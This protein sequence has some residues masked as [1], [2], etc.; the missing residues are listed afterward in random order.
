MGRWMDGLDGC[1]NWAIKY[2]LRYVVARIKDESEA[3]IIFAR[4]DT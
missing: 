4:L 2:V 1:E 3:Q